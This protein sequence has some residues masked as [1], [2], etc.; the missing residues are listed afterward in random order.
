MGINGDLEVIEALIKYQHSWWKSNMEVVL[1]LCF[2]KNEK[3]G[4]SS[5]ICKFME[6]VMRVRALFWKL[7]KYCHLPW[8]FMGARLWKGYWRFYNLECLTLVL[9]KAARTWGVI[10]GELPKTVQPKRLLGDGVE[11]ETA[12]LQVENLSV[13]CTLFKF[14]VVEVPKKQVR[15]ASK[16]KQDVRTE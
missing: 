5:L 6:T 8:V 16:K 3:S 1:D 2:I 14:I 9:G 11:R 7:W 15:Y 12:R 13:K 10:A 4:E